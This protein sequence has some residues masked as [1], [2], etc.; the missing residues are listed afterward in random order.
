[1]SKK[2]AVIIFL[3]IVIAIVGVGLLEIFGVTVGL[4]D[5]L[6]I[7]QAISLG[8]DLR[9]GVYAVFEAEDEGVEEFA[10]KLGT[11]ME[12]LRRRLDGQ[13]Y[14]EATITQQ[15]TNRIR[16]EI[17]D[18]SDP[19]KVMELI[20]TPAVLEFVGPNGE[21][22]MYGDN[23]VS[24]RSAYLDTAG[25]VVAFKLDSEGAAAFAAA[26]KTYLGQTI[27]ILLDGKII[28]SAIV[29]TEISGGE[30]YI[31]GSFTAESAKNLAVQI[32][33]GALPLELNQLNTSTIS[34]TLGE[35]AIESALLAGAIGMAFILVF[36]VAVYGLP[37]VAADIALVVYVILVLFFLAVIPGVQLSLP[38]IAGIILGSGM[39]VDSN[40][41]IFECFR[42]E[43]KEGKSLKFAFQS[44]FKQAFTTILDS[45]ITT[46]IAAV[47][48][49]FYGT[50]SVK[51]YAITLI[52]GI[53]VSLF[54]A[55]MVTKFLMK[56]MVSMNIT[57]P[58]LYGIH[59]KKEA[60]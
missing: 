10:T 8:L 14:T 50:G 24:A 29:Q 53:L 16:V 15:G 34:P 13:G 55:V 27:D 33:S 59:E 54:T 58:V 38:G 1:M 39:A 37:G 41:I 28:S 51:G 4:Y 32:E 60:K 42:E 44:S 7:G 22:I 56:L 36:M 30:G 21:H 20:G 35:G 2:S 11:T 6:P 3:A 47:V 18:V 52:I 12:V 45:N 57:N 48:L 49:L 5:I 9:G 40:V 25:F 23:I 46:L 19:N 43:I 31:Q 26:T 17:P